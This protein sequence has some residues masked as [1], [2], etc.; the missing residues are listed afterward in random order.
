MPEVAEN[1]V[2]VIPYGIDRD[3]RPADPVA[4]QAALK[5]LRLPERYILYV[6]S[7]EPRKNLPRLVESYRRLIADARITE[8]LVLAGR[9][10]WNYQSLVRQVESTGLRDRVHL[11]GY[12][13]R[14]DLPLLYS[15]ARL[16]V[17]PSVYEGFGFPPLEAL[18]CGVPTIASCSSS[19]AENL[20]GAAEL[21]PPSD[22]RALAIAI[23]RLLQDERLR[24][25]YREKGL[26]RAG[27]F[28]WEKTARQTLN[29]YI[30]LAQ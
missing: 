3:F 24:T 10:G 4:V 12:I 1:R 23:E 16:F 29:C 13:A 19:L 2:R 26:A 18:A 7:I 28:R 11:P 9:L 17:Y 22:E 27:E 20:R 5:R 21:V 15:G 30:E 14:Q 6:G 25:E 8:H